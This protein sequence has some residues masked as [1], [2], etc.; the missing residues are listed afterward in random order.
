M[1]SRYVGCVYA[2]TSL[3]KE[4]FGPFVRT[5]VDLC[6][7]NL[8]RAFARVGMTSASSVLIDRFNCGGLLRNGICI[9]QD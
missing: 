9:G 5:E 1:C 3:Y 6:I 4:V 2:L 7:A 8:V